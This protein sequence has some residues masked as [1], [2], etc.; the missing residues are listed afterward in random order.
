MAP[1]AGDMLEAVV[2]FGDIDEELHEPSAEIGESAWVLGTNQ[3][4]FSD[5]TQKAINALINDGYL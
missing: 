3:I 2:Y 4:N 1:H 5:I